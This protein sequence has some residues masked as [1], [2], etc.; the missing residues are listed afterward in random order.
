MNCFSKNQFTSKPYAFQPPLFF[1]SHTLNLSCTSRELLIA[2]GILTHS[3]IHK[4][5]KLKWVVVTPDN[6]ANF[7][8]NAKQSEW[9]KYPETQAFPL[10]DNEYVP[11]PIVKSNFCSIL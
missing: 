9:E 7:I 4:D 2:G 10:I 6:F 11:E 3:N 8:K 1:C 5:L